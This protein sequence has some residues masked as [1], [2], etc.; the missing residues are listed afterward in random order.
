MCICWLIWC[1]WLVWSIVCSRG[2]C[3]CCDSCLVDWDWGVRVICL[4][5]GVMMDISEC[6]GDD[7]FVLGVISTAFGLLGVVLVLD[8][9]V[10]ECRGLVF[11]LG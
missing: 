3:C 8:W 4:Y 11:D 5:F 7:G 2:C 6:M 10:W 1:S 9:V